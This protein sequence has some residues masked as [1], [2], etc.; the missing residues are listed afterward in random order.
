MNA[1]TVQQQQWMPRGW[2]V[3]FKTVYEVQSKNEG[4]EAVFACPRSA[5]RYR[6]RLAQQLAIEVEVV[7]KEVRR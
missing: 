1:A 3:S 2:H 5:E 4:L 6:R 7:P